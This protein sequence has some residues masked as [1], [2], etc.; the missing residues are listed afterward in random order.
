MTKPS[1]FRNSKAKNTTLICNYKKKAV[2][3]TIC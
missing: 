3:I 1:I 2:K